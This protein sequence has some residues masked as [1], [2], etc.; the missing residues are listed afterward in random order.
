MFEAEV[1]RELA[2]SRRSS[3]PVCL[4]VLDLD[5]LGAF[6]MLRGEREGDR[7]LKEVA[8]AW[9]ST[10]RDVD[11]VG[12][13]AGGEFAVLLPG[14]MLGEAVEVLDRVRTHTP[15]RQTASAGVAQWNGEEPAELLLSRCQEAL[16]T[17][18]AAGRDMTIAAE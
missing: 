13:L 5:H 14:C 2:R 6:N 1:P 10:L 12:R 4:A 3:A 16:A 9:A 15:R 8:S 11:F 7:L 18:K 17:A